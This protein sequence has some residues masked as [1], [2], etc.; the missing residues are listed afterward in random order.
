MGIRVKRNRLGEIVG[1]DAPHYLA[2]SWFP[3]SLCGAAKQ[4]HIMIFDKVLASNVLVSTVRVAT[5]GCHNHCNPASTLKPG[6]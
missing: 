1:R 5:A 6:T 4:R 3:K 2:L